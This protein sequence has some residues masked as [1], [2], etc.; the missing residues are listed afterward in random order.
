MTVSKH[1][2]IWLLGKHRLICTNSSD[3]ESIARLMARQKVNL[4]F[5]SPPYA[6]KRDYTIGGISDWDALMQG[7]FSTAIRFMAEDGQILVNLGFVY[8]NRSVFPYWD[9]WL[10][11]MQ[12]QGWR[13][14]GWYVWDKVTHLPGDWGGRLAPRHEFIFHFNR[15]IRR[16][17]KIVP[18]KNAGVVVK[19][20]SRSG[21]ATCL[22]SKNGVVDQYSHADMPTQ[23]YRIPDSVISV[24]RQQGSVN[25]KHKLDHPAVFPVELPKFAMQAYTFEGEVV[26]DPFAGSGTT[27]IAGERIGRIVVASE[28]APEYV[29]VAI[30]RWLI[31]FPDTPPVLEATG[32]TWDEV[33][34]S[35]MV[36]DG[37][38]I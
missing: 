20:R 17:N 7:V 16:P 3:Y 10:K 23:P 22:R 27:I 15:Q 26:F 28:F 33:K 18:N 38:C 13:F 34:Q 12:K 5:T 30:K 35:R 25:Q 21:R 8:R 11:W 2:D 31:T 1:G 9:D 29:D 14:F 37:N 6:N 24:Q 19:K 4:L 32:E 36:D